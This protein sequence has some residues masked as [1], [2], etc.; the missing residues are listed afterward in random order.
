MC[1]HNED[2]MR[3][4]LCLKK[5]LLYLINFPHPPPPPPSSLYH[6]QITLAKLGGYTPSYLK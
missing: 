1:E 3:A 2:C 6:D 4:T 5:F